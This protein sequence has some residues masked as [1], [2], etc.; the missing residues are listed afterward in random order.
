MD[1]EF[2][3]LRNRKITTV[4]L[5]V[6]DIFCNELMRQPGSFVTTSFAESEKLSA[7]NSRAM[8]FLC[9]RGLW[10][11]GRCH[12]A[13]RR[14]SGRSSC[15]RHEQKGLVSLDRWHTRLVAY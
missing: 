6:L 11:G 5:G 10:R 4:M 15:R 14:T 7:T 13:D 12:H 3:P 9:A 2:P 8:G 1:S